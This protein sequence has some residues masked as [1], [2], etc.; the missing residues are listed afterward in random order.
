MNEADGTIVIADLEEQLPGTLDVAVS[1]QI[2]Q[3]VR[4]EL[5]HRRQ[6]HGM[7]HVQLHFLNRAGPH[8]NDVA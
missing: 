7:F 8:Q 6:G 5:N 4:E 1:D 2:Q 3:Q